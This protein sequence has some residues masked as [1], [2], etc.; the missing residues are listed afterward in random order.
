[1]TEH[2]PAIK[3][4]WQPGCSSCLKTKEFLLQH[5]VEF[6]SVNVLEDARGFED[7]ARF[8][9]RL[10]PVVARGDDWVNGAVFRDVA[11]IAGFE[12]GGHEML[13]PWEL[14]E[15]IDAI[16]AG[17]LRLSAQL[18]RDELDSL[19]PNRP[20]SYRELAYH[21]FNIPDVFLNLVEHG[22]PMT[23]ESLISKLPA[24][25][26][27]QQDLL[28]YGAAVRGRLLDWWRRN[29]VGTDFSQPGNVYYGEVSL[30]EVLERTAWHS[31]QHSRQLMLVLE[32]LLHITLD[33]AIAETVYAGLP[34]PLKIWDNE[35]NFDDHRH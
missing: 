28:D 6:E 13:A 20:R 35:T 26:A 31:G 22:E 3:V 9:I 5:G 34:L 32:N 7:L 25:M 14:V 2:S 23:Y 11:R 30:H 27:S 4:Y 10:V 19:L 1:M 16:L 12:W 24:D 33:G 18:P 29:G 15:R 17:S 8:G 21:I